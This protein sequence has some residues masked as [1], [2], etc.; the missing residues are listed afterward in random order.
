MGNDRAADL[1]A[2]RMTPFRD[3]LLELGTLIFFFR[4]MLFLFAMVAALAAA[5]NSQDL[6]RLSDLVAH[7]SK[8]QKRNALAELRGLR[9]PEASRIALAAIHDGDE[10]ISATAIGAAAFL[11]DAEAAAALVPL[12]SSKAE[13]IRREAAYALGEANAASALPALIRTATSDRETIVRA[14]A[15][16]AIGKAGDESSLPILTA[17]LKRRPREDDEYLRRAAARS[18]GQIAEWRRFRRRPASTP[19]NFL[20]EKLKDAAHRPPTSR[21]GAA[22]DE[23]L[24]VLLRVAADNKES[25]D[26]RREAAFA[27]GAIGDPSAV[28]LLTG[29][30]TS[31][32]TY[33]AEISREAL[34]EIAPPQ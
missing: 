1:Q 29:N 32:D 6:G 4:R 21:A 18:I 24:R 10:L 22:F 34:L 28:N 7:G 3:E 8:E 31:S 23:P 27:L 26:T 5:A 9:S 25:D 19:S 2:G 16:A 14:A 12:L 20:P 13:F 11:P 17:V 33:L 30:L 15:V